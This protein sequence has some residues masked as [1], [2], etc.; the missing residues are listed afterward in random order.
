MTTLAEAGAA[1]KDA[2]DIIERL[3]SELGHAKAFGKATHDSLELARKD[4]EILS[5]ERNTAEKLAESL[6]NKWAS[7]DLTIEKLSSEIEELEQ[8]LGLLQNRFTDVS[9]ANTHWI[10]RENAVSS[11]GTEREKATFLAGWDHY[12]ASRSRM[13]IPRD[14]IG[15]YKYWLTSVS[16]GQQMPVCDQCGQIAPGHDFGCEGKHSD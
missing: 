3:T 7:R 11:E 8:T 15:S 9:M 16:E 10:E 1:L 12:N 5:S 13:D 2:N 6:Q 4:Y 14:R